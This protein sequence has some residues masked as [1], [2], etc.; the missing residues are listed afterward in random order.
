MFEGINVYNADGSVCY[1]KSKEAGKM[2]LMQTGF[3]RFVLP[4]P[5]LFFPALAN[6]ALLK[7]RMWPRNTNLAK[8]TELT[9]CVLSLT[10]ALPASIAMFKQQSM[11]TRESID[12]ELKETRHSVK[13]SSTI[14]VTKPFEVKEIPISDPTKPMTQ[15]KVE[16]KKEA[17]EE[18]KEL[19]ELV[20][21]FYFNKGM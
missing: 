1:G 12:E 8:L 18:K 21:E 6:I 17:V 10:M 4:L 2:A 3:S 20:Q 19:G 5:V 16:I 9:L 7:M 11:L 13:S 15:K 14:D